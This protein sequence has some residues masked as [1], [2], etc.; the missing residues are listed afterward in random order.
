LSSDF[1]R[2]LTAGGSASAPGE[3]ALVAGERVES[4]TQIQN[5]ARCGV[6]DAHRPS[7]NSICGIRRRIEEIE[8]LLDDPFPC[9]LVWW[10]HVN[11]YTKRR[12][13]R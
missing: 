5:D 6:D 8:A 1:R 10:S 11:L 2:T 7:A 12:I 9:R 3:V 13:K 4:V